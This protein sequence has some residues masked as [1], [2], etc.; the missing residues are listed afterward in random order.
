MYSEIRKT[1]Y[2]VSLFPIGKDLQFPNETPS[3]NDDRPDTGGCRR[4]V[5]Q[6]NSNQCNQSEVDDGSD[7]V[8]GT[9]TLII[10]KK[11]HAQTC[12]VEAYFNGDRS[13]IMVDTCSS[14][15][16]IHLI[17]DPA[18]DRIFKIRG[19]RTYYLPCQGDVNWRESRSNM[20]LTSVKGNITQ[21]TNDE[22]LKKDT[23][24]DNGR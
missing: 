2:E 6:Q 11:S 1:E 12:L 21:D 19:R 9:T 8:T 23:S 24:D 16:M 15:S 17:N 22:E 14:V 5:T 13:A 3:E 4:T 20:E 18:Q 7:E 10:R